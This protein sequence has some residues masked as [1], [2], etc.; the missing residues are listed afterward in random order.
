MPRFLS[1]MAIA[2]GTDVS[3]AS[4]KCAPWIVS[5][6]GGCAL[7]T[8][9]SKAAWLGHCG[10]GQSCGYK[11]LL[12]TQSPSVPRGLGLHNRF[13]VLCVLN[14][15]FSPPI[16]LFVC[17]GSLLLCVDFLLW[18]TGS[19]VLGTCGLESTGSVTVCGLCCPTA[20]GI[21]LDQGLNPCPLHWPVD[22]LPLDH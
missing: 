10:C 16:Y 22:S 20:Y 18:M 15:F 14:P 3:V 6:P 11:H 4:L 9:L 1:W 12:N 7:W 13:C 21:F 8:D 5:T 19:R 2:P 17:T